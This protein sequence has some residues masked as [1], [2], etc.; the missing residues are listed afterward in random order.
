MRPP[1][2]R[3]PWA[4]LTGASRGEVAR[5]RAASAGPAA[6]RPHGIGR[7]WLALRG[8]GRGKAARV[9]EALAGP[10]QGRLPGIEQPW[11]APCGA[12]RGEATRIRAA[13]VG[14]VEDCHPIKV[15]EDDVF[16][17]LY[18]GNSLEIVVAHEPSNI[19]ITREVLQCLRPGAWLND[20]VIN[21]YLELLKERERRE[22]GKLCFPR[23]WFWVENALF[24][25]PSNF[26]RPKRDLARSVLRG[27]KNRKGVESFLSSSLLHWR[28]IFHQNLHRFFLQRIDKRLCSTIMQVSILVALPRTSRPRQKKQITFVRSRANTG[29]RPRTRHQSLCCYC[30]SSRFLVRSLFS[31]LLSCFSTATFRLCLARVIAAYLLR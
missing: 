28:E 12:G 29:L 5:I 16:H 9:L 21:L 15:E 11:S 22:P 17:A 4:A 26:P 14:F 6:G 1:G 24:S 13:S 2:G 31:G 3:R 20:E 7:P 19:R 10:L 8:A 30:F 18:V 27:F 23:F 25:F